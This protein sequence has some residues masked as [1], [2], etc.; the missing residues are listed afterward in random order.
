MTIKDFGDYRAE[1]ID[2]H[3]GG[4]VDDAFDG[5]KTGF[6]GQDGNPGAM[7][8][9]ADVLRSRV[10]V[11]ASVNWREVRDTFVL[12]GFF[13]NSVPVQLFWQV[14]DRLTEAQKIE[15]LVFITASDRAPAKG[16]KACPIEFQSTRQRLPVAHTCFRRLELPAIT[17]DQEMEN[18]LPICIACNQSFDMS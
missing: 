1:Q 11:E 8:W 4:C 14:F 9:S 10:I 2:H 12:T 13:R 3:L 5:L 7:D 17:S 6:Y 15:M 18:A 16:F